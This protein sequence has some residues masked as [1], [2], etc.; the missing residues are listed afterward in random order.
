MQTEIPN[1]IIARIDPAS[2]CSSAASAFG[3]N[4]PSLT[5]AGHV[6]RPADVGNADIQKKPPVS[7]IK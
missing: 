2:R 7:N 1:H 5:K 6:P 4:S 3:D